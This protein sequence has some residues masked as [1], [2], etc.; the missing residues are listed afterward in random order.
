MSKSNYVVYR[1]IRSYRDL[2]VHIGNMITWDN[3]IRRRRDGIPKG[4]GILITGGLLIMI[5]RMRYE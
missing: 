4:R 3:P 2:F 5:Q 1:N